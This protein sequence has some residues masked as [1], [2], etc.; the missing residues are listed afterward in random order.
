MLDTEDEDGK[1]TQNSSARW[2]IVNHLNKYP[3]RKYCAEDLAHEIRIPEATVRR[4]LPGLFRE[5]LI[6]REI[7]LDYN[8]NTKGQPKHLYLVRL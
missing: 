8:C 2:L 4:E 3:G 7:N 5:G 6:D 1:P